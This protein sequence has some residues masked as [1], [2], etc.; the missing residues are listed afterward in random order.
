MNYL[1]NAFQG[2]YS[3]FYSETSQTPQIRQI[4]EILQ[5]NTAHRGSFDPFYVNG[6][7]Y[8][9][10]GPCWSIDL[11]PDKNQAKE[12]YVQKIHQFELVVN[13]IEMNLDYD[14]CY[15]CNHA[16][17]IDIYTPDE[18]SSFDSYNLYISKTTANQLFHIHTWPDGEAPELNEALIYLEV[19][20]KVVEAQKNNKTIFI[21]CMAGLQRTS[22]FIIMCELLMDIDKVHTMTNDEIRHFIITMISELEKTAAGRRPTFPQFTLLTSDSFINA[23]RNSKH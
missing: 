10:Y 9:A 8:H 6:H 7:M 4:P 11:A 15:Y 14:W 21:H 17:F 22:T 23:V 12:Q 1:T 20:A 2:L 3:W 19:A 13:L 5:I 16:S 18:S